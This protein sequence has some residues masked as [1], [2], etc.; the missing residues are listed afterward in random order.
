MKTKVFPRRNNYKKNIR[1]L[2][3]VLS[4]GSAQVSY[5]YADGTIQSSPVNIQVFYDDKGNLRT[6]HKVLEVFQDTC[7]DRFAE[8]YEITS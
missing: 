1:S 8:F 6:V 7:G 2:K 5:F 3:E 4:G